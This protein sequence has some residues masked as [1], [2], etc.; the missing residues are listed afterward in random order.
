MT[1]T[2]WE[3]AAV[4]LGVYAL[5]WASATLY[6]ELRRPVLLYRRWVRCESPVCGNRL[7]VHQARTL[8]DLQRAPSRCPECLLREAAGVLDELR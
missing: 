5:G 7:F 3:A 8:R 4:L 6:G 2:L 1:M